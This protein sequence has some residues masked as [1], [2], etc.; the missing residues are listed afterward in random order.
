MHHLLTAL[1]LLPLLSYANPDHDAKV[2]KTVNE[3]MKQASV[4]MSAIVDES[5]QHL[6]SDIAKSKKS[7]RDQSS[8]LHSQ[9]G[10]FKNE[11]LVQYHPIAY[12]ILSEMTDYPRIDKRSEMPAGTFQRVNLELTRAWEH[13]VYSYQPSAKALNGLEKA[14]DATDKKVR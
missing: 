9:I 10:N 2:T 7:K 13:L 4:K 3:I 5:T 6:Y 11:L 14:F 12:Q 1:A 8:N